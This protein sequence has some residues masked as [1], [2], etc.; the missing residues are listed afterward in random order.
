MHGCCFVNT[1]FMSMLPDP[2]DPETLRPE[3]SDRSDFK[4]QAST[5]S[6]LYPPMLLRA[7]LVHCPA[8]GRL[9]ILFDYLLG[10]DESFL[11]S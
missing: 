1:I 6:R 8:L 3:G 11:S 5:T 10:K 2:R 7:D 9:D 4:L